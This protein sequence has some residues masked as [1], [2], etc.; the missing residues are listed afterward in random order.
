MPPT[1]DAGADLTF[2]AT[3]ST[4]VVN[5]TIDD[6]DLAANSQVAGFEALSIAWSAGQ[7]RAAATNSVTFADAVAAGMT[8]AT[9]ASL[10]LAVTDRGGEMVTDS[11]TMRYQ[12]TP[13]QVLSVFGGLDGAGSL[14]FGAQVSEPDLAVNDSGLGDFEQLTWEFDLAPAAS[15]AEI[16]DGFLTGSTTV[17]G[18]GNVRG[19]VDPATLAST[20]GFVCCFVDAYV[21]VVD[22]SGAVHS[23]SAP[24][25]LTSGDVNFDGRV[26]GRDM[27]RMIADFGM[28]PDATFAAG[29]LNG[30]GKVGLRDLLMLRESWTAASPSQLVP[31]PHAIYLVAA[32]ATGAALMIW[33]RRYPILL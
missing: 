13:P 1:V 28:R 11:L 14:L 21:N 2:D 3:M 7:D 19:A 31:E 12:N 24:A 9:E 29:D 5:G 6:A 20:P 10:D 27:A 25:Y 33:R 16:G 18:D 30:D 26:D 22:R 8:S 4:A 15:A 17:T 23:A 32:V